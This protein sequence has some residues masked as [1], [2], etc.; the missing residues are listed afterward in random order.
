MLY[1]L[2]MAMNAI[3]ISGNPSSIG[4][5]HKNRFSLLTD[6]WVR[7]TVGKKVLPKNVD[8]VTPLPNTMDPSDAVFNQDNSEEKRFSF[9]K[10]AA[11]PKSK[12]SVKHVSNEKQRNNEVEMRSFSF[13]ES[14]D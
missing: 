11:N 3:A 4:S 1:I 2:L 12:L 6:D 10:K 5:N 7:R 9:F 8:D 14:Q 13:Q